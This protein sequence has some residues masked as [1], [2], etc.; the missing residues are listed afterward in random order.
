MNR[1]Q[2]I[3]VIMFECIAMKGFLI[4]LRGRA[5]LWEHFEKLKN[6]LREYQGLVSGEEFIERR[7]AYCLHFLDIELMSATNYFPK[8]DEEKIMINR[9]YSEISEV[10]EGN[11]NARVHE[12]SIARRLYV[13]AKN[14]AFL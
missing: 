14:L 4:N 6:A 2:C 10:I 8:S 9:I 7:I 11:F 5:F 3:D 12:R 13:I 1:Q